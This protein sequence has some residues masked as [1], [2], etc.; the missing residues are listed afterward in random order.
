MYVH[1]IDV[2]DPQITCDEDFAIQTDGGLPT[3]MVVWEKPTATDNSG[4]VSAVICNPPPGTKFPIGQRTVDCKT[5]DR[6]G[7]SAACSFHVNI[8]GK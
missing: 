5:E 2:E 3:A 8:T 6:S 7:N 1:I 4:Q